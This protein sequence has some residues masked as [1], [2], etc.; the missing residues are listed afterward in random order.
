MNPFRIMHVITGL[1]AGGAES[2]LTALAMAQHAGG[3]RPIVVSM[4]PGGPNADRLNGTGVEMIDLG[5]AA[6]RPTFNGLR[7]LT[8]LIRDRR[9]DIVQGWMY[10]ANLAASA[11]AFMA[12]F[13]G[14]LFWG[15]RCSDMD[16]SDYG[17]LLRLVIRLGALSA[18]HPEA[19]L[20][21]SRAGIEVHRRLGYRPRR[22]ELVENGIDIERFKP[23]MAARQAVRQ[24]LGLAEEDTVVAVVARHDPM[25]DYP[26]FLKALEMLPGIKAIAIGEGTDQLSPKNANFHALGRRNDVPRLLN[27]ADLLVSSSAYGEGFSNA[28]AEGMATGLPVVATD[29]GDAAHIIGSAGTVVP[30]ADAAALAHAIRKLI[31]EDTREKRTRLGE[32]AR[33]R[34]A[35]NFTLAAAYDRFE[36]LY[37]GNSV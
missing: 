7:R 36:A 2:M 5:M 1:G 30:P 11:A 34:I 18:K 6:G 12:G 33:Q 23:D 20:V 25:K 27:A 14:R 21:N 9:P 22:F 37:R 13:K 31:Q 24:E 15:I 4:I 17:V 32:M 16:M 35:E 10:H 3:H 28:I 26:S 8:R 29:V 19:I